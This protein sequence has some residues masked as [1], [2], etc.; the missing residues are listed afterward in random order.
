MSWRYLVQ[1]ELSVYSEINLYLLCY[2]QND[3]S[4]DVSAAAIEVD[5]DSIKK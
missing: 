5:F 4:R 1:D 2:N 3:N